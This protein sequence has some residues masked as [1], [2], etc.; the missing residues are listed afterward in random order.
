MKLI[1]LIASLVFL[2][3]WRAPEIRS[4]VME[5]ASLDDIAQQE[6]LKDA[7]M[8]VRANKGGPG[9]DG[10]TVERFGRDLERR[11]SL[12]SSA[13]LKGRYRPSRLRHA[14]IPKPD[15]GRRHLSIP[16]V[17]DRIVQTATLQVLTPHLDA[18]MTETSWAYRPK[19]GVREALREVDVLFRE[20]Y[21]WTVDADIA[22]YFDRV[23][24]DR[25]IDELTIWLDDERIIHLF[26]LWLRGFSRTGRGIAQGSPISPL[27]ANLYLH[28]VDRLIAAAGYPLVRYADDL[29]V[30]AKSETEALEARNVLGK[31][32]KARGLSLNGLKTSIRPPNETFRF[33][34]KDIRANPQ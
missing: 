13:L 32:L 7:W 21:T 29:V 6:N 19:R 25:L 20:G 27:L 23:P 33:L 12:L 9:G 31:L 18:R 22:K 14:P 30:L 26:G 10:M 15:G 8:R 28:P 2:P 4:R 17:A 11:L 24:H 1:S 34:G 5:G 16:S 3:S